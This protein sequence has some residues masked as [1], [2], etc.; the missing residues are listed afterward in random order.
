M[1][2]NFFVVNAVASKVGARGDAPEKPWRWPRGVDA[3]DT[4][5]SLRIER[6][7]AGELFSSKITKRK[8]HLAAFKICGWN[9]NFV[10][11]F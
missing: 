7:L 11:R 6:D 2:C 9:T 3:A 5:R 8:L 1:E 10:A 4:Q